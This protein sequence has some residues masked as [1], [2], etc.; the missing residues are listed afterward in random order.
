M[1]SVRQRKTGWSVL[2]REG[3]QQRS[4]MFTREADARKYAARIEAGTADESPARRSAITLRR[5]AITKRLPN[6][7]LAESSKRALGCAINKLPSLADKPVAWVAGHPR[8]V[9]SAIAAVNRKDHGVLYMA[10]KRCCDYAVFDELIDAHRLA[11]LR[12][13]R[14]DARREFVPTT[15]EQRQIMAAALGERALALW[16]MHGCGL[17]IGEAIGL[18]GSDFR[19]GFTAVTIRRTADYGRDSGRVKDGRVRTVPNSLMAG[20]EGPRACLKERPGP[21]LPRSNWQ[22]VLLLPRHRQQDHNDREAPRT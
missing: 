4:R 9:K 13:K 5:Y 16:L 10:V 2:W 15:A 18:K 11:D 1:A 17:R 20:W 21:T 14:S 22:G 3:T 19:N 8:E 7:E 6:C 12:V